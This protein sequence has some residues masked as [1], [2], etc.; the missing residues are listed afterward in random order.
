M[1][2]VVKKLE[3]Y[4]DKSMMLLSHT[5]KIKLSVKKISEEFMYIAFL[6]WE[7]REYK[8]YEGS[9]ESVTDYAE[10]EH[11]IDKSMTSRLIQLTENFSRKTQ[12]GL[13][14][15]IV[16]SKYVNYSQTQLIE[17][18]Q[19]PDQKREE[20]NPNM[21]HREIRNKVKEIKSCGA[22]TTEPAPREV[23]TIKLIQ[24]DEIKCS[25][26]GQWHKVDENKRNAMWIELNGKY[27]GQCCYFQIWDSDVKKLLMKE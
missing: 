20:I 10:K 14:S 24:D 16:D 4:T 26:C 17:M 15:M 22:A 5:K 19:I 2:N 6:L 18:I 25:N 1:G 8:Y 7:V 11:S 23:L 21:S 3:I 27:I 13:P 9:Y 12:S